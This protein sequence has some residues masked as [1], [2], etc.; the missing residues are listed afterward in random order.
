MLNIEK[1]IEEIRQKP[2]HIRLRYTWG[3]VSICMVAVMII[4]FVSIKVNFVNSDKFENISD[5]KNQ[6]DILESTQGTVDNFN[7]VENENN[8]IDELLEEARK[9]EES[10]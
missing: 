5:T 10:Q 8:S 4:W 9:S 6:F 7:N 1:K 2:E 3:M